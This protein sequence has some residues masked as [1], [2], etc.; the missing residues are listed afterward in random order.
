ME[1]CDKDLILI[2][3]ETTEEWSQANRDG[4]LLLSLLFS[5]ILLKVDRSLPVSYSG[6]RGNNQIKRKERKGKEINQNPRASKNS[7][8]SRVQLPEISIFFDVGLIRMGTVFFTFAVRADLRGE[9][10]E[11]CLGRR[12]AESSVWRSWQ[13]A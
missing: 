1:E 11:G 10:E 6:T 3:C 12:W 2:R 5:F 7:L 8:T 13:S 9:G 4:A